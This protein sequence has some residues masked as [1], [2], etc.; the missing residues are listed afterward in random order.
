MN[1]SH[2][3]KEKIQ[4]IKLALKGKPLINWD[5]IPELSVLKF[6]IPYFTFKTL[7]NMG[8]T[9]ILGSE[10]SKF[11]QTIVSM[12]DSLAIGRRIASAVM[13]SYARYLIMLSSFGA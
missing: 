9:E 4:A 7:E 12:I 3:E 2:L 5:E 13:F 1:I 11:W 8:F 10:G 6:G